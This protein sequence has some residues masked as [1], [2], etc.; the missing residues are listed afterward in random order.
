M[1]E[2][3]LFIEWCKNNQIPFVK[4][5]TQTFFISPRISYTPK[6]IIN[7]KIFIDII[8]DGEYDKRFEEKCKGFTQSFGQIILIPRSILPDLHKLTKND[9]IN[10]FEIYI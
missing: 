8:E 4:K 10:R 5:N 7:Y 6:Y 9:I 3:Q 1:N 2:E